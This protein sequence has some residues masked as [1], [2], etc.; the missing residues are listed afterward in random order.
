[1]KLARYDSI[2]VAVILH[3]GPITEDDI[4]GSLLQLSS[5]ISLICHCEG[6]T[7]PY[8]PID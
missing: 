4:R 1:M 5:L 2:Q 8:T 3:P 6:N 7:V